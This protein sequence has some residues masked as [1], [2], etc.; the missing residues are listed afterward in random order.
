[1]TKLSDTV[2]FCPTCR[3]T[4]PVAQLDT[5]EWTECPRCKEPLDQYVPWH[6]LCRIEADRMDEER[7]A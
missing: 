6:E 3:Y 5:T 7:R 4:M 2:R 1:M